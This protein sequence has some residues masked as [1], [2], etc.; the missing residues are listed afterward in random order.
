MNQKEL[1]KL[2][3]QDSNKK[4]V[5]NEEAKRTS[6]S[7]TNGKS[8]RNRTTG[9][10]A[11]KSKTEV[12]DSKMSKKGRDNDPNWYFTDAG[13]ADA[14]SS[15]AFDQYLG[16]PFNMEL[17]TG[18]STGNISSQTYIPTIMT[19]RVNP[20]PGDT[21][22]IRTGI[23]M[24][25][26]KTYTTLSSQNAKTTSYAPQDITTLLLSLGEIISVMEHIRRA[27]GVA[28]TYNQ[29]NRAM[30]TKLLDA[31]GFENTD[32]LA[33]LAQHR[34][35]FNSWVTAINKLPFL[36]NFAYLYK[37]ADIYQN[38]YAD[39]D[40]AMAQLVFMR[41]YSTWV[42][43]ETYSDQGTGLKTIGLPRTG[44]WDSWKNV[45]LQ[46]ITALFES[47]TYNYIYSDILNYSAKTGAKL[48]FMDF[49]REDYVVVP[50]YNRN[51][52]LQ[53]HNM[54]VIGTPYETLPSGVEGTPSND[55]APNVNKNIVDYQPAFQSTGWMDNIIDFDVAV[56]SLEDKIEATRF[57][58]LLTYEQTVQNQPVSRPAALP[59]HY[60]VSYDIDT[61]SISQQ[62][63]PY[64][65]P[66][67]DATI[68]A[69]YTDVF[70]VQ[71]F[72]W[73]PLVRFFDQTDTT[74]HEQVILGDVNYYTTLDENWYF[75]VN[76]LTFQAL[77]AMR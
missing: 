6:K 40:S 63:I 20:C 74:N 51:F 66:Y 49:L 38:V 34:L 36:D 18:A 45:V 46:M 39:S 60:V 14:A 26:L 55:V 24:A 57:Q 31:M 23:N 37:C 33:N 16:V 27:F 50:V 13:I 62:N 65:I 42:M 29:R 67:T 64:I 28:F 61:S 43:D 21:S 68:L 8:N 44:D 1:M 4:E 73:A 3:T 19:I 7:R 30:P 22:S 70:R 47:T 10:G 69:Q 76:D 11:R 59:D 71:Q 75:R 35:E 72:D 12:Q 77:F 17:E 52:M 58:G 32:F 2:Q 53:V 9:K 54:T 5:Q 56:P 48:L 15:F 25:A 41:P